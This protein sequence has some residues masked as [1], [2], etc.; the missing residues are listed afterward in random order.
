[1][2]SDGRLY[3]NCT[4]ARDCIEELAR[5]Q[6]RREDDARR[7]REHYA[8][9]KA[10]KNGGNG[11]DP[12]AENASNWAVSTHRDQSDLDHQP[13]SEQPFPHQ[14]Y[15]ERKAR[16]AREAEEARATFE[17]RRQRYLAE[18][19]KEANRKLG[20]RPD[21][22]APWRFIGAPGFDWNSRMLT[23]D[24]WANVLRHFGLRG[25]W[26]P[27]LGPPPGKLGCHVPNDVAW[28][29]GYDVVTPNGRLGR[30]TDG[31]FK[32]RAPLLTASPRPARRFRPGPR[33]SPVRRPPR[34]PERAWGDT[35]WLTQLLNEE[36]A[37]AGEPPARHKNVLQ[38]TRTAMGKLGEIGRLNFQPAI[39]GIDLRM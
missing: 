24:D 26:A 20:R 34:H 14:R 21:A 2:Y 22:P 1:M 12:N 33:A 23:D 27:S 17:L 8:R 35:V 29:H 37:T 6:R 38:A 13:H 4:Q 30:P 7:Q 25:E 5:L 18:M 9:Q 19:V 11:A 36:R 31:T 10:K 39:Y 28:R 16:E 32:H 3:N 15:L